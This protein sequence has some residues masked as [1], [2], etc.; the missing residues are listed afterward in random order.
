MGNLSFEDGGGLGGCLRAKVNIMSRQNTRFVQKVV[1]LWAHKL[2][3]VT[4]VRTEGGAISQSKGSVRTGRKLGCLADFWR[5]LKTDFGSSTREA[6]V[7]RTEAAFAA[8]AAWE[9]C[10]EAAWAAWK[11]CSEAA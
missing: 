11:A 9:A 3:S 6:F 5:H 8:L 10:S 7:L 2:Q 1:M 4:S